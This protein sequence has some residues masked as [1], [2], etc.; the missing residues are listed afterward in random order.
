MNPASKD[1]YAQEEPKVNQA[2]NSSF[3]LLDCVKF[4]THVIQVK[5]GRSHAS[6]GVL[7]Y[8]EQEVKLA[9]YFSVFLLFCLTVRG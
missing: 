6:E 3:C 5:L 2:K 7:S 1:T 4:P 9:S 8:P